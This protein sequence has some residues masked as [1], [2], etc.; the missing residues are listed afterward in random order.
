MMNMRIKNPQSPAEEYVNVLLKMDVELPI[1]KE[2][3]IDMESEAK[4]VE[5]KAFS[6]AKSNYNASLKGNPE[7]VISEEMSPFNK[8]LSFESETLITG[9]EAPKT[10]SVAREVKI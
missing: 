9:K 6:I 1:N 7:P 10:P 8:E 3:S 2:N 5:P 4:D